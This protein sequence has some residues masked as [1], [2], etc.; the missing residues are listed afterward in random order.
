MPLVGV[1]TECDI[2]L[3]VL[4]AADVAARLPRKLVVCRP[5]CTHA[6]KGGMSDSLS[7][8][9]YAVVL[10]SREVDMRRAQTG[11]DI[12]HERKLF[13]S[14]TVLDQDQGLAF[15]VDTGAVERVYGDDANI[16]G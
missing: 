12:F 16:L 15:R 11:H 10:L 8:R 6:K 7:V 5:C 13:I 1:D 9:C 3:N 2:L 14:G 4:N